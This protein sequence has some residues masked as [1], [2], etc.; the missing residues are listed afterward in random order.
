MY[1][2]RCTSLGFLNTIAYL[3]KKKMNLKIHEIKLSAIFLPVSLVGKLKLINKE[4]KRGAN[5]EGGAN[6]AIS[7]HCEIF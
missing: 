2:F 1:T 3:Y 7:L 5:L 4:P 6:L